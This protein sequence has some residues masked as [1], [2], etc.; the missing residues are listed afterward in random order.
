MCACTVYVCTVC[1]PIY[2]PDA[3]RQ[4]ELGEKLGEMFETLMSKLNGKLICRFTL[5][6][7]VQ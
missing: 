4:D 7:Y 6:T 3:R 5:G 1:V 2:F